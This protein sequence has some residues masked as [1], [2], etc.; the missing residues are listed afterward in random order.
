MH[1]FVNTLFKRQRE[2]PLG[3]P[4]QE[5]SQTSVERVLWIDPSGTYLA[6]IDSD[7]DHRYAWPVIREVA[8]LEEE[9]RSGVITRI[10]QDPYQSIYQ[11]DEV[12]PPAYLEQRDKAWKLVEQIFSK[13]DEPSALFD[14]RIRGPVIAE[15]Q[16][17]TGVAKTTLYRLLRYYWQKGQTKNALLPNRDRCGAPG[18]DRRSG[19]AKR[20]RPS[21]TALATSVPTG[22]NVDEK[23]KELFRRGIQLYY[24]THECKTRKRSLA[25]YSDD[26]L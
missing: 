20:G 5:A 18:L 25:P 8:A 3:T 21:K 26:L 6:T 1:F 4:V 11:S 17:R 9:L 2:F 19:E 16:K 22:V 14:S 13:V 15:I 24:E 12:F 7:I 10:E 23:V